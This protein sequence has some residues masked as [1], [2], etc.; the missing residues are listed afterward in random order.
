MSLIIE[1]VPKEDSQ[2]QRLLSTREAIFPDYRQECFAKAFT[3]RLS[4][5]KMA[6]IE[7]SN[8]I[9]YLLKRKVEIQ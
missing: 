7:G 8:R 2:V 1:F 4:I 9:L 3:Q 5:E 6:Q